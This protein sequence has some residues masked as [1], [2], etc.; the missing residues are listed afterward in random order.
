MLDMLVQKEMGV[1][2]AGC[3]HGID[4]III[5]IIIIIIIYTTHW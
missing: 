4:L 2:A 3:E 5:I 1:L